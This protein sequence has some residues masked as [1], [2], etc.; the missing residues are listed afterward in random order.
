MKYLAIG[1]KPGSDITLMNTIYRSPRPMPDSEKVKYDKGLITLIYKDNITGEKHHCFSVPEYTYYMANENDRVPYNRLFIDEKNAIPID[2]YYSKLEK[3]IAQRTGNMKFF[4]GNITSGNRQANQKLHQHP[5]VFLSD[6]NIEDYYRKAFSETYTNNIGPLKKSFF[7]IE[8]DSINMAG[9]FPEMGE[10]PIN[11]ISIVFQ[12]RKEV[13]TFLLRNSKNPQIAEFEK[14]VSPLLF[15]ELK[16][17]I[18]NDVGGDEAMK[19]FGLD[20]FKFNFLFYDENKE[21]DLIADLFKAINTYKPDFVEAWNMAFDIP[22]I[23]ARIFKLGYDPRDVMCHPDF[24]EKIVK[25]FIDERVLNEIPERGDKATI[26][27]YSVFLDQMIHFA[28]RRKGQTQFTSYSLDFIGQVIAKVKKH[29]YKNITTNIS[30]LPYK[31]YKTFVFY[32]IMDTIVQH[33]I[34]S[35]TQDLEYIFGKC[36]MNNTRYHKGHRQTVYL[37]NRGAKEFKSEGFIMGNNCNRGN[38]IPTSKFPGAFVADPLL[39]NDY[40]RVKI[41]G[42]PVN[43][44]NNLDDFDYAALYPSLLR[45]FNI[46]SNTQIGMLIIDQMIHNRENIR[47]DDKWSRAGAFM[48]D[49][50]SYNWIEFCRRWFN[51]AGYLDLYDDVVEYYTNII[52]PQNSLRDRDFNGNIIPFEIFGSEAK[53]DPYYLNN[54]VLINP[55]EFYKEHDS[56]EFTKI[57]N[58]LINKP[59]QSFEMR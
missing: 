16:D 7:D 6:M 4:V 53:E 32:N 31:D 48:E 42:Y 11:A 22:Y 17:F 33:C 14:S 3:D 12:F 15:G 50:Q 54:P 5:D 1:Y 9:D 40:S 38:P 23:I 59:N 18:R 25:Y 13:Y 19:S 26:S 2:V 57:R 24:E 43:L 28:S 39:I 56:N 29:D 44:F 46:A 51:L 55:F 41:G 35:K 47:K 34:E 58:Q 8:A 52:I 20:Q 21:I 45:Q 49:F 10:C 30:E 36:I 27:S 37:T